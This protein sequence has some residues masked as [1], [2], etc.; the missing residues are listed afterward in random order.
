MAVREPLWRAKMDNHE[1]SESY[2]LLLAAGNGDEQAVVQTLPR[3]QLLSSLHRVSEG[4]DGVV[5]QL[6][7]HDPSLGNEGSVLVEAVEK[8]HEKIVV[9]LLHHSCPSAVMISFCVVLSGGLDT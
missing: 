1:T 5:A 6:L 4:H 9:Q 7:A 3:V 8:G 2:A